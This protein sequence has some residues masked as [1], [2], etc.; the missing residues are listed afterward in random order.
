MYVIIDFVSIDFNLVGSS[1][2]KYEL[3]E[4]IRIVII[5]VSLRF[6]EEVLFYDSLVLIK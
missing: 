3:E 6:I 2:K 4:N 5:K 1:L